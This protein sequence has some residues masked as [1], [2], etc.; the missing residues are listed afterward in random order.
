[1]AISNQKSTS[2]NAPSEIRP[3][4]ILLC[5]FVPISLITVSLVLFAIISLLVDSGILIPGVT[6]TNNQLGLVARVFSLLLF[7]IGSVAIIAWVYGL[8]D[9]LYR[10][11][12]RHSKAIYSATRAIK[13]QILLPLII[14]ILSFAGFGVINFVSDLTHDNSAANCKQTTSVTGVGPCQY[15]SNEIAGWLLLE[16]KLVLF[17]LGS[18]GAATLAP[19][20]I[21]G[22]V[23]YFKHK[24]NKQ[25]PKI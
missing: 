14:V 5:L 6:V 22:V 13:L 12:A 20:L 21:A 9:A 24:N 17:G 7:V 1:M 16:I 23:L 4:W 11:S 2:A 8:F 19:G 15:S 3:K 18:L 10:L 25:T